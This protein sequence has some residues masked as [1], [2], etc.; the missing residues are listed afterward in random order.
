MSQFVQGSLVCWPA[1]PKSP[2]GVVADVEGKR[3]TV[4]FDGAASPQIFRSDAAVLHPVVLS[5]M[6]RR[7]STGAVGFVQSLASSSPP[8][9]Q[10]I[11]DQELLIVPEADL[12]PHIPNDPISRMRNLSLGTPKQFAL[13]ATARRYAIHQFA[14]ELVSLGQ[15]RVDIKPHQVSVVHRVITSY[16]HRYLLCDEVGLGKTIEAGMVLKELRARNNAARTI[17]VVPP[18]LM[19][20]WQFEMK[21]K[22]NETFAI[23]NSDTIKYLRNTQKIDRNPFEEYDSVIVSNHWITG[24]EWSTLASD[25][26]WDLVIVDEA[27]HAR[28]TRSGSTRTETKLFKTVRA[29]VSPDSFSKRAAL[30]LTATPMQLDSSELYSLVELLDPAL[31]PTEEHFN[32]HRAAVPGLSRLVH[33]LTD[34]GFPIP[35]TE[36][37]DVIAKVSDWLQISSEEAGAR[38]SSG[39]PAIDALCVELSSKHLLSEVLIR[40]RK[41]I[42]GGFMPRQATRWEVPLTQAERS[43]LNEVESYVREGYARAERTSDSASGFVMVTYQKMMASSIQAIRTSLDRR[44]TRLEEI[45]ESPVLSKQIKKEHEGIEDRLDNDEFISNLLA[46]VGAAHRDEATELKRLVDLLTNLPIDSKAETLVSQ[47]LALEA[48][49]KDV[50]VL[51]FT[52]FRETQEYLKT[53]LEPLGWDVFLFHGQMKPGAKDASVEAFKDSSRPCILLST[54]AGGEGRNFQFCHILINYDLPWNP[55]RVEQRIGRIDRIGQKQVVQVFNFWVKGTVE[56]RVLDVL[57]RRIH[58]FEETVGGLDPILGS[59][60]SDFT[61]IMRLAG[62]KREEALSGFEAK[63]ERSILAARDAEEKFRDF[64]METKSFSH[65]VASVASGQDPALSPKEEE[66]FT[67]TLL[68]D[69]NTYIR[70][71]PGGLYEIGFHEPFI[72]DF[73]KHSKDAQRRKT[74][75]FRRDIHVDSEHV[76]YLGFGHPIINDLVL[77]VISP[78]YPGIT[79]GFEVPSDIGVQEPGWLFVFELEIPAFDATHKTAAYF[80]ADG[81]ASADEIAGDSIIINFGKFRKLRPAVVSEGALGLLDEANIV[82]QEVALRFLETLEN[83][84]RELAERQFSREQNKLNT[85]FDYRDQV[86]RDKLVSEKITVK[87]WEVSEDTKARGILPV[88]RDKVVRTERLIEQLSQERDDRLSD[89]KMRSEGVGDLQCV[90]VARIELD[91]SPTGDDSIS[92]PL[93]D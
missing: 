35:D 8:R 88:W 90:A 72:S 12:R 42:V 69:V 86:A 76:E 23:I 87:R 60:E 75:T 93:P 30:L 28:V 16:P 92:L 82:A 37:A 73:P 67:T 15:S 89:L 41:K 68:S 18:N 62:E 83:E 31:F 36:E 7:L 55:M 59:A 38:L 39:Q 77:R 20:Q 17:V 44:R 5:G 51:L 33:E 81:S 64:I 52:Q 84:A 57:E 79:A 58:I 63:L 80:V 21:N 65:G 14:N 70:E 10:I 56:E 9:W 43:A 74:V 25:A 22:F 2:L 61:K 54:E 91:S 71:Q 3:I 19:R 27:H 40:N 46:G 45:A 48:H 34:H 6:V 13:A 53:Q 66:D 47:L 78:T 29:L 24:K 11:I 50:K 26:S 32:R 4:N 49:E 1:G 85:Y